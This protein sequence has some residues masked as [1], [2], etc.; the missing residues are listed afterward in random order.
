[1][2][3]HGNQAIVSVFT[4]RVPIAVYTLRGCIGEESGKGL[5]TVEMRLVAFG[6]KESVDHDGGTRDDVVL[7]G[8][9]GCDK[10]VSYM[11]RGITE[12]AVKSSDRENYERRL[13]F[14]GTLWITR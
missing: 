12:S 2:C 5:G 7:Y 3:I 6:G 13:R 11:I 10:N 4:G 14:G 1:M 8:M 9:W